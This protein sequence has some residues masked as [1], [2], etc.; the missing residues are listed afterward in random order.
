MITKEAISKCKE[1]IRAV[2]DPYVDQRQ[3]KIEVTD[4]MKIFVSCLKSVAEKFCKDVNPLI[5]VSTDNVYD[6]N[7]CVYGPDWTEFH[8]LPLYDAIPLEDA[9]LFA[10]G[11]LIQDY[12]FGNISLELDMMLSEFNEDF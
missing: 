3:V 7:E 2:L 1:Q 12:N 5:E 8:S 10:L 4:D 6:G 9:K 11:Y